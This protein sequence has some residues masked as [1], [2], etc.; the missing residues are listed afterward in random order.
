MPFENLLF[1]PLHISESFSSFT[2][3]GM[4]VDEW[5][6]RCKSVVYA[7]D[8]ILALLPGIS[9]G[10]SLLSHSLMYDLDQLGFYEKVANDS[11]AVMHKWVS[12][13][14]FTFRDLK[15]F[16]PRLLH[17]H[18]H[19]LLFIHFPGRT[20]N[21]LTGLVSTQAQDISSI[22]SRIGDLTIIYKNLEAQ[23]AA[24]AIEVERTTEAVTDR[25]PVGI[26]KKG[27]LLR[28]RR[29]S[30]IL[31]PHKLFVLIAITDLS[32]EVHQLEMRVRHVSSQIMNHERRIYISKDFSV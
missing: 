24:I 2:L 16:S 12:P 28:T 22:Q 7:V 1:H 5:R 29:P 10:L 8:S 20:I 30:F 31:I 4:L 15:T 6:C 13:I 17:S 14:T 19:G 32:D 27:K 3:Q 9:K 18:F 25:S 23:A 26:I 21:Q 11:I